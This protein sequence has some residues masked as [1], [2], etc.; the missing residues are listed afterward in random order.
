MRTGHC[1]VTGIGTGIGKTVC[2][3]V[4]CEALELDYWKPVQSGDLHALDSDFVAANTTNTG[5]IP[6]AKLL[7][8]PLSPHE[9]ARIDGIKLTEEDFEL[10]QF[11]R[12]TLIEGAGGLMVPLNDEGLCYLDVF[13]HW[14]LPVYVITRHYLGSINHTLLT[15]N[16]LY[17][18]EIRI[19]GLIVNGNRNEASERIY[20]NH[21]PELHLSYIPE[22]ENFTPETVKAAAQQWK[23]QVL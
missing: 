5:I 14:D 4:I 22:L 3:A 15:L 17:C 20:R 23:D 1:I 7:S 19:A 21:F 18:R 12:T 9:A 11:S 13:Q 8:Q 2:S 10:P 6:A 16:A